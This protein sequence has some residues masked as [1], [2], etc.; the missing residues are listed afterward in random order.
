MHL[1]TAA[2]GAEPFYGTETNAIRSE[3]PEM[4]RELDGKTKAVWHGHPRMFVFDN[5]TGFEKKMQR[6]VSRVGQLVGLPSYP[7]RFKK[8]RL[9]T[10]YVSAV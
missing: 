5:S 2:D 3:T 9:K 7:R 8:F 1:V 10:V 4:A 6:V